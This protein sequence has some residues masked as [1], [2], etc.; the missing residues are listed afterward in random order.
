MGKLIQL[1]APKHKPK[2]PAEEI[3]LQSLH[4]ALRSL[5]RTLADILD[6]QQA[7]LEVV[8]RTCRIIVRGLSK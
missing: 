5:S 1:P 7:R 4:T 6:E 8:E 2:A 3:D